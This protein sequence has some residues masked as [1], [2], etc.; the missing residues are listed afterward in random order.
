MN[1][2]VSGSENVSIIKHSNASK[3]Q[4]IQWNPI[5]WRISFVELKNATEGV[6]DL[7]INSV[8]DTPK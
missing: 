3:R 4:I 8:R 5:L 7:L 2:Y 6:Y 1:H